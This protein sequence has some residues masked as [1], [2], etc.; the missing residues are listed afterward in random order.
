MNDKAKQLVDQAANQMEKTISHLD[1]ELTKLRAGRAHTG[2][3]D[4]IVVDYYGMTVPISNAASLNTTDAR[5]LVITP[6]E[7]NMLSVIERAIINSNIGLN[8]QTDGIV[9]RLVIP[10]LTEDRRK[11]LVKQAKAEAEHGKV[12]IRNIRRDTNDSIKKLIKEGLSEDGAKGFEA[13]VQTL[14]DA[15]IVKIDKLVEVKEKEI[16]TV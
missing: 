5:T 13:K 8:P 14:T 10:P 4:G 15:A 3:L 7:K 2:M 1:S 9:I 11:D 16:M 6:F 12:G